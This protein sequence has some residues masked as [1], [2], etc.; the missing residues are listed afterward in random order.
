MWNA[1]QGGHVIL[2]TTLAHHKLAYHKLS[3][4]KLAYHVMVFM[5]ILQEVAMPVN[6]K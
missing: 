5:V 3:Y 6:N 1:G 2:R 4:H